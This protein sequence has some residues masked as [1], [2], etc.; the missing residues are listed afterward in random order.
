MQPNKSFTGSHPI[1]RWEATFDICMSRDK[2]Y[3]YKEDED[4]GV[5][6]DE[7]LMHEVEVISAS[8]QAV[9][10]FTKAMGNIKIIFNS[11]IILDI[12]ME[13]CN[14]ELK[15]RHKILEIL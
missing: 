4:E 15:I 8:Y 5:T 6:Q 7:E 1:K 14:I 2:G 3:L 9:Q 13:E 12:I 10:K 11:S